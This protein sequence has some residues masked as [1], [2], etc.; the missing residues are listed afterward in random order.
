MIFGCLAVAWCFV[1]AYHAIESKAME[2]MYMLIGLVLWLSAN[3]VWMT[4]EVVEEDDDYVLPRVAIMMET[5]IAWILFLH[6]VLKPLKIL[7]VTDY[8]DS[9]YCRPELHCRFGYFKYWRQYEHAHTLCWLGKDLSWNQLNPYTWVLCLIPTVLIA[10]DFI[11][12]TFRTKHM[13]EDCVHYLAQLLWVIGNMFWAMGNIFFLGTDD[14]ADDAAYNMFHLDQAG[15]ARLRNWASWCLFIA[16]WP[17]II[18]YAVWIPLTLMN[19]FEDRASIIHFN[20]QK[21][22]AVR[23]S[24]LKASMSARPTDTGK[25]SF[26]LSAPS[27][28]NS[29]SNG[30]TAPVVNPL[31]KV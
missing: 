3:F 8:D 1:L 12:V 10:A 30:S 31:A 14:D 27:S 25:P 13:M 2:E 9:I 11:Y 26:F 28:G 7:P 23:M 5:A 16:Y 4:G 19:K 6:L 18:L 21:A 15:R 24:E 22:H 29:T 20:N 17:L